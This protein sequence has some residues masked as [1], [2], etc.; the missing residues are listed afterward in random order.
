MNDDQQYNVSDDPEVLMSHLNDGLEEPGDNGDDY[1]DYINR[2]YCDDE[3]GGF[4]L[5][6]LIDLVFIFIVLLFYFIMW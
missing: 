6:A 3:H 5:L 4:V 2:H 1:L